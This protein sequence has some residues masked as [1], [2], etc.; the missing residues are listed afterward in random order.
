MR[1]SFSFWKTIPP[2]IA[3]ILAVIASAC[4]DTQNYPALGG[5]EIVVKDDKIQSPEWLVQVVDSVATGRV[6]AYDGFIPWVY[7]VEIRG[8]NYVIVWDHASSSLENGNLI[9]TLSGERVLYS[10][11]NDLFWVICNSP[12]KYRIA[13]EP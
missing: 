1:A 13:P 11:E 3:F 12:D 8:E 4:D 5:E 6:A 10:K 2:F 7:L 9:Y